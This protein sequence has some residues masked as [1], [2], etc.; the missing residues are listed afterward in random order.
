LIADS[1]LFLTAMVTRNDPPAPTL[2]QIVKARSN[3]EDFTMFCKQFLSC[4]IYKQEFKKC[5]ADKLVKDI[6][7]ASDKAF[8]MVGFENYIDRWTDQAN[9]PREE[10]VDTWRK[11]KFTDRHKANKGLDTTDLNG[12]NTAGINRFNELFDIVQANQLE[13]SEIEEQFCTQ[14]K[15]KLLDRMNSRTKKANIDE[16]RVVAVIN[17]GSDYDD[18][19][20]ENNALHESYSEE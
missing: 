12:W 14:N 11:P 9:D 13:T 15:D 1:P 3:I 19:D 16:K 17:F 5:K 10:K 7:T 20:D 8:V 18:N 2:D 4:V 6:V